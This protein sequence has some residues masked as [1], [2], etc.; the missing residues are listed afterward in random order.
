[1]DFSIPHDLIEDLER[2]K[3]FIKTHIEPQLTTWNQKKEI[4]RQ[5][6]RALGESGWYGLQLRDNQLVTGSAL[7][8]A[9]LAETVAKV[10]PGVAVAIL[11][12]ID[13]GLAG[14]YLF[15]SE[16][17]QKEFG[18]PA[19]QGKSLMCLGNTESNAG[20]DV[21]GIAMTVKK[22]DDG[23]LLNGTKAYVTNGNI[24]DWAIVNAISDPQA[25][26][27][28][29]LSMFLVDLNDKGVSRKKLN[30]QVWIPSDLTRLQFKD[31]FIPGNHLVGKQGRGLQQVL[32]VFTCSRV[33]IAALT[34]GTALGAFELAWDH[35][36]K[37]KIFGQKISDYQAKSFEIANLYA[38][39]EAARLMLWKACWK[40]DN[41]EDFR[42][43]SSLAKYLAVEVA[44]E[45]TVWAADIFG[46][47]AV[48]YEHPIHKFPLDAW[49]ASLGEGTQDVQK[50][51]IFRELVKK[52]S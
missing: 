20:S 50:L 24:A 39:M 49:A 36:N 5:L 1:M 45:I 21:A 4:P 47:A 46:A 15:G 10:S 33:P 27:N 25:S 2:F 44:R 6:F 8:E 52:Y 30:K 3:K 31:V 38:K 32:T 11:A 26:R 7:R 18:V 13:L 28:K 37:R 35:A 34:L 42:Q 14:L 12:H 19:V 40:V 9:M 41:G 23:W 17:L 29:R 48:I 51:V 16:H 43:E 22:V